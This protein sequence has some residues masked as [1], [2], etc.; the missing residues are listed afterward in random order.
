MRT[1]HRALWLRWSLTL[2]V[3]PAFAPAAGQTGPAA[4]GVAYLNYRFDTAGLPNGRGVTDFVTY[5]TQDPQRTIL[6]GLAVWTED[7]RRMGP[8][9]LVHQLTSPDFFGMGIGL[10]RFEGSTGHL[11]AGVLREPGG[12]SR[13]V[14]FDARLCPEQ[15]AVPFTECALAQ[16][17]TPFAAAQSHVAPEPVTLV[18][19]GT[20]LLGLGAAHRRRRSAM[21]AA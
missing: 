15:E 9:D 1:R 13:Y 2:A 3:L 21:A 7:E 5:L 12:G 10:L 6:R 11:W 8:S 16:V 14:S 19:L 18:L 4:G 17:N 20:G